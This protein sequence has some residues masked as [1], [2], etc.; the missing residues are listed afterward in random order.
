M[1]EIPDTHHRYAVR[2]SL[3]DLDVHHQPVENPG[4]IIHLINPS[5]NNAF[6]D[7]EKVPGDT[8]NVV[9]TADA[10]QEADNE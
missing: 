5:L 4:E 7:G 3:A 2:P 1:I 9:V 10:T 6:D 8:S